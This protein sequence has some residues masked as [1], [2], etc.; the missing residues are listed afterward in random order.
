MNENE[1]RT[2]AQQR[3]R[4]AVELLGGRASKDDYIAEV[5]RLSVE[6]GG[7]PR[8]DVLEKTALRGPALQA[9]GLA[10]VK[11]NVGGDEEYQVWLQE[12]AQALLDTV[13]RVTVGGGTGVTGDSTILTHTSTTTTST[14]VAGDV[15]FGLTRRDP[16]DY[17]DTEQVQM[18]NN[19]TGFVDGLDFM[20]L[21]AIAFKKGYHHISEGP[22]G[23]GKT[24]AEKE[25]CYQM[26]IPLYRINCKDGLTWDD[27]IGY[28]TADEKGTTFI[29]GLLTRA[30]RYGGIMYVDEMTS[31]L[32]AV[33]TGL[34]AVLDSGKLVVPMTGETLTAHDDFRVAG[35]FNPGYAGT[36]ELN[37]ATARRFAG[38]F[39]FDYLEAD[40]E[41]KVIQQQSGVGNPEVARELV[42][43]ANDLRTLQTQND[44]EMD[45]G[46]A[47]LVN[48]MGWLTDISLTRAVEIC[49][50]GQAIPDDRQQ[51]RLA[52]RQRLSNFDS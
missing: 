26:G 44:I 32:P 45:C 48:C 31:A 51:V 18:I 11:V 37:Q 2:G 43:L 15:W 21:M 27:L 14:K 1:N 12:D 20:E 36:N 29:D 24:M 17:P 52:C 30:V 10:K 34:N 19:P 22:T 13:G 39:I 8:I 33:M 16:S 50:I 3:M 41:V 23:C 6:D 35:S 42:T 25:F 28:M 46:T 5:H 7:S 47:T 9:A 40:V 4:D 49:I 38:R